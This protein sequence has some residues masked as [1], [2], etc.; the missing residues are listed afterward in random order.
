VHVHHALWAAFALVATRKH[1][2]QV[3]T[4][5]LQGP[6]MQTAPTASPRKQ[7]GAAEQQTAVS[8]A[9][10]SRC[11]CCGCCCVCFAAAR[12]AQVQFPRTA[13]SA[14]SWWFE[15]CASSCCTQIGLRQPVITSAHRAH[16]SRLHQRSVPA[17]AA[18]PACSCKGGLC[19][20]CNARPACTCVQRQQ[21]RSGV[22]QAAQL[23]ALPVWAA[24]TAQL[25][26]PSK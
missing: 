18:A 8:T 22:Q 17:A 3:P 10:S 16:T 6:A 25:T 5:A 12:A 19:A 2:R 11:C 23:P 15:D 4:L 9:Y 14:Q 1:E 13:S 24:S 21:L 20:A 7:T 26:R